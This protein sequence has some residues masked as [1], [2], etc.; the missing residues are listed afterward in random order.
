MTTLFKA[1]TTFQVF[2]IFPDSINKA[3]GWKSKGFPE[4]SI[5]SLGT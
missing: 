2:I 4:E 5:T 3:F 1:S